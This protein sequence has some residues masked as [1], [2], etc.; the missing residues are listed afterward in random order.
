MLSIKLKITLGIVLISLLAIGGTYWWQRPNE[1]QAERINPKIAYVI[2]SLNIRDL[3]LK[4]SDTFFTN[5]EVALVADS[6]TEITDD[7]CEQGYLSG[8]F[9]LLVR[10]INTKEII[11][12][13][14]LGELTVPPKNALRV[15]NDGKSDVY[16]V[17]VQQYG[18][19]NGDVYALYAL[20]STKTQKLRA[21]NFTDGAELFANKN[22]GIDFAGSVESG[23]S[24]LAVD[25][26]DNTVGKNRTDNY[27]WDGDLKFTKK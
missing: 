2:Q 14:N 3:N 27:D 10:N 5:E 18:A 24:I 15:I 22:K 11:D 25:Y 16:F 19:C 8:N 21:T 9:N 26:Y 20:P 1:N 13:V 7:S 4:S 17:A 23:S 6:T 12:Q